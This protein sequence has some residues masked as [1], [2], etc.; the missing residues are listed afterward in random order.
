M[1]VTM[2]SILDKAKK[3]GYG[4]A[5]PN[6]FNMESVRAAFEAANELKAPVIIDVGYGVGVEEM[7]NLTYYYSKKYPEVVAALNLDHGQ[8][9][10]EAVASIRAGFTSVM[11]D[12]STLPYEENVAQVKE[13]VKMAHA[14]GVSVEA[15]LG[16]VGQGYEYEKT[17][18]SG[19]TKPDEAV[20][21][22]KDT[23]IDCLAVAVGTSHGVYTG[24]PYLDFNL[25]DEL[26]KRISIPLVLHGGSGTGDEQLEKAVKKGIQKINLFTDLSMAGLET[27]EEYLDNKEQHNLPEAFMAGAEGYKQKLIHYMRLFGSNGRA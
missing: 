21:F 18:N 12:R 16:H 25:L 27:L 8:T 7:S 24:T 13:I 6:V 11:A 15:E 9:F 20:N 14:V 10:E 17:R 2:K 23:D 5:A 22:I 19:L 3:E 26:S 4:V 1:L